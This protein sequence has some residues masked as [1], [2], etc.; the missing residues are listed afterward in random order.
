MPQFMPRVGAAGGQRSKLASELETEARTEDMP[1]S[2]SPRWALFAP[3]F[4]E[5]TLQLCHGASLV[6]VLGPWAAWHE[7]LASSKHL[8]RGALVPGIGELVRGPAGPPDGGH[9]LD[10]R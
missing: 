8:L 6:L 10:G 9:G 1:W 3:G 7:E 5:A 4:P 2:T